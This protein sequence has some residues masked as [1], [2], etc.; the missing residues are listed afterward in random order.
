MGGLARSGMEDKYRDIY[1]ECASNLKMDLWKTIRVDITIKEKIFYILL[2]LNP[3]FMA[4]REK[5]RIY[6]ESKKANGFD[7][8]SNL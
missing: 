2:A 7:N 6:N 1:N 3:Y 8:C 4:N 5:E